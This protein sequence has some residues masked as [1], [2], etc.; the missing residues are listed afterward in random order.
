M[1]S[2]DVIIHEVSDGYTV[3]IDLGNEKYKYRHYKTL[4]GA[5][6]YRKKMVTWG[7]TR[8]P[9]EGKKLGRPVSLDKKKKVSFSLEPEI[10]DYIESNCVRNK[11]SK[12]GFLEFIIY[13]H[14]GV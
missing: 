10:V 9:G 2:E 14:M 7:G 5:E 13:R 6:K 8:F 4:A 12:S 1:K 11:M 3:Q